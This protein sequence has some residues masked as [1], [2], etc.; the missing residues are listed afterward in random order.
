MRLV[1]IHS[2]TLLLYYWVGRS[3]PAGNLSAAH[4]LQDLHWAG[5]WKGGGLWHEAIGT[6]EGAD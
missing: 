2:V 5:L 1:L 6:K 3:L 4:C